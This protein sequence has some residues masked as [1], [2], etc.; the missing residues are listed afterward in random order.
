VDIDMLT[1]STDIFLDT[2]R[3]LPPTG[4]AT[5]RGAFLV[6]PEGFEPAAESA[7]D[8]AYMR[9]DAASDSPRAEAQHAILAR[10]LREDL[11][12]IVFPGD[13]ATP[14]A[15]FPNNVFVTAPGVLL[16]GR[17]RHPVRQREAERTDMRRFFTD[18]LGYAETDLSGRSDLVAEGTGTLVI[19]H[20]RG[21]GYCGLGERCDEAGAAA[22]HEALG[23]NLTFCFEL[24]P[25]EYHTNVVLACLAGRGVMM[26]PDGFRD[27]AVPAA[28]AA[29]YEGRVIVLDRQQK[30][31]YAGNAITLHPDR[32][33]MSAT[34]ASSLTGAQCED[35]SHWGLSIGTV[36][37]DEIEKAGGSL[38]CCVAEIF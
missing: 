19:D 1:R 34:A 22:M 20:A 37:L 33:W 6:S 31:C 9:F 3:A 2:F 8:N 15:V 11:P 26:A 4:R 18:L 36:E 7:R 16:I 5:A 28:I 23:L 29:A 24:A 17:M 32:V 27:P 38:R 10:A 21:V 25:G 30:Q 14:E 12:V 35:L 13:P